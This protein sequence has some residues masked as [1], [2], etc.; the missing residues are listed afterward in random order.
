MRREGHSRTAPSFEEICLRDRE[1]DLAW[2]LSPGA[3][4]VT[5]PYIATV[6]D[7]EHR[8][9]PFFPEVSHTGWT[10]E[11]REQNFR[12][13]LP[14]AARVLTGTEAGKREIVEFY[15]VPSENIRVIAH[16]AANKFRQGSNAPIPDVRTK[17]ELPDPFIFYPA[18][19]W[20]HKNHVNL[21]MGLRHFNEIS[22]RPLRLALSGSDKGNLDYIRSVVVELGLTECVT[23]LGFVPDQDMTG[24]YREALALFY[25]TLFGPDNLPPLEAF[26]AECPVAAS[27]IPGASEQLGDAALLF[28]PVSPADIAETMRKISNPEIRMSLV[29]KGREVVAGRTPEKY[30]AQICAIVDEFAPY[31]RCWG[32]NYAHT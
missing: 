22:K 25:P 13:L 6:W 1:L 31:R 27:N 19:F 11:A 17:Y 8:K 9:Q 16:P 7:L 14:R 2:L 5:A 21:L 18:Q 28:D 3:N 24:L 29:A 30:V 10:W 32:R 23:F 4:P 12:S 26:A 20:P 15:G